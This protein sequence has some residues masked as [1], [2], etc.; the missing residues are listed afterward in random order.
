M[1]FDFGASFKLK[2][3]V[4]VGMSTMIDVAMVCLIAPSSHVGFSDMPD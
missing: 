3:K 2:D 4:R 1:E